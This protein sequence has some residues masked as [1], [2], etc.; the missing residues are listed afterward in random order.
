MPNLNDVGFICTNCCLLAL[1]TLHTLLATYMQS[2]CYS[3]V[4][5]YVV[6]LEQSGQAICISGFMAFDVPPPRGPLWYCTLSLHHPF[7]CFILAIRLLDA[8]CHGI[9]GYLETSSWAPITPF[10]TSVRAGLGSPN[11][12]ED[13]AIP[14]SP[15]YQGSGPVL[16]VLQARVSCQVNK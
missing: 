5:Q 13:L 12:R 15:V 16:Y 8:S 9:A 4:L 10:S 2:K 14:V 11:P 3:F 6:K 7:A 1:V